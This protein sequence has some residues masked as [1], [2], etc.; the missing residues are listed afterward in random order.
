MVEFPC[1][2]GCEQCLKKLCTR[3][4]PMFGSL[5]H[6]QLEKIALKTVHRD[7]AKGEIILRDGVRS[8]YVA[9][10]GEGS[11]KATKYTADG[12]EQ[13]LYVFSEGDF[14]GE[15]NLLF[16]KPAFYNVEALEPVELCTLRLDDFQLILRQYPDIGIQIIRELGFRLEHLEN[17]VQNM[18]VRSV[19]ARINSV[20]LEL[21]AKYGTREKDGVL[22]H[23]PLSREG[24]ANYVG[25]ARETVSRKLGMLETDGVIRSINSRTMLIRDLSLLE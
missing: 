1:E 22:V 10:I 3:R 21:A 4:I 2:R 18:G 11:V 13:I 8:D 23:M 9:I 14:F 19:E 25:I 6:E 20:L 7:C 16:Q 17:A 15:Q 5:T 24:L 12:R